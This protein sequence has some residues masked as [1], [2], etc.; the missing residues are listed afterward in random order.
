M[1]FVSQPL[2]STLASNEVFQDLEFLFVTCLD[3]LRVVKDITLVIGEHERVVDAVLA[4]L[5]SCL[6]TIEE[7]YRCY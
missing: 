4:S 2:F 1:Q 5:A 6:E 3:S 7:K